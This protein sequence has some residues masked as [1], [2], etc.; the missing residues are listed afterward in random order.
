MPRSRT[1]AP[2]RSRICFWMVT[3]RAVVG[4]SA[5]SRSGLVGERHRNHHPL[6][7]TAGELVRKLT[8]PPAGILD[9]DQFQ[10]PL[11]LAP[12]AAAAEAAMQNQTLG[13]L[14]ADGV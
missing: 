10:E 7:L 14:A 9:T 2:M 5:M 6:A 11:R 13:H 12:R 8:Q 1:C 4:S 3:S